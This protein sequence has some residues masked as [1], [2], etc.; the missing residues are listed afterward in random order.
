M[1]VEEFFFFFSVAA[2]GGQGG[3]G[4]GK[5]WGGIIYNGGEGGGKEVLCNQ[6]ARHC[7]ESV[8]LSRN[9]L[10]R[11][12]DAIEATTKEPEGGWGDRVTHHSLL[13]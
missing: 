6:G 10:C 5:A 1:I 11:M 13:A 8:L 9:R 12:C 2:P 7:E 3:V 4:G